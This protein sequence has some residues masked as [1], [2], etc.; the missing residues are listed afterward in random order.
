ML[1]FKEFRVKEAAHYLTLL[2][3]LLG[4]HEQND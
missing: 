2:I 3:F 1:A 4:L